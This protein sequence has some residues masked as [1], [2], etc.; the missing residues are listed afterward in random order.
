MLQEIDG[1]PDRTTPYS[2]L[3]HESGQIWV[4]RQRSGPRAGEWLFTAASLRAIDRLYEAFEKK[5]ILP[6]LRGSRVS[7][8][9][10]PSL[11]VREYV[12]PPAF[13]EPWWGWLAGL[14]MGRSAGTRTRRRG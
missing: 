13:K 4:D 12:V 3:R 1:N 8:W 7:F 10:L 5:P 14:A 2:V 9:V 11:Y 6:E